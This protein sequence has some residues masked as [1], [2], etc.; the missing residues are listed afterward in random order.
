MSVG[1]LS[2]PSLGFADFSW[3]WSATGIKDEWERRGNALLQFAKLMYSASSQ[4]SALRKHEGNCRG[5]LRMRTTNFGRGPSWY[6]F[7]AI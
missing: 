5:V 4:D 7:S 1:D 3:R 6:H 2:T